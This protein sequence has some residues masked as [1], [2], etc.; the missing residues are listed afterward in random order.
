LTLFNGPFYLSRWYDTS[1]LIRLS[2][3]YTGA[4]TALPS[5]V[6]FTFNTDQEAI[7]E[8]LQT[9]LYDAAI[10]GGSDAENLPEESGISL[11]E[12]QNKSWCYVFNCADDIMKN[13]N[14]RRAVLQSLEEPETADYSYITAGTGILPR[15]AYVENILYRDQGSTA[16]IQKNAAQAEENWLAGLQEL[17][18][19][20]VPI[21]ILC[22]A[23][24]ED[25]VREAV[26]GVQKNLGMKLTYVTETYTSATI[27]LSIQVTARGETELVSR[28]KAGEYQIALYPFTAENSS[29][30]EFVSKHLG[31][32]NVMGFADEAYLDKINSLDTLHSDSEILSLIQEC[33]QTLV[34]S[35]VVSP[36]LF[37]SN[38]F[39]TAK[40]VSGVTFYEER[41]TV[42]LV[43]ARRAD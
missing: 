28:V 8:N 38:Y 2:E 1:M 11:S 6:T 3:T 7:L 32:G 22:P 16:Q 10:I 23:E 25:Y 27:D 9:G 43:I 34:S 19:V 37:A 24:L 18:A 40:G 42:D 35:A 30:E 36:L 41:G 15:S 14:I 4:H 39:A 33:E 26:Q 5:D 17:N 31:A 13:E 21:Q 20:T 29:A 12:Y